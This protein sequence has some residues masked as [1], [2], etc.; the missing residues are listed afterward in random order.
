MMN[1]ERMSTQ[2][3]PIIYDERLPDSSVPPSDP[4]NPK[5]I[6]KSALVLQDQTKADTKFDVKPPPYERAGFTNPP[7]S[8]FKIPQ[9]PT[10]AL[11]T[12]ILAL[13]T[14]LVLK[15]LSTP[16]RVLLSVGAIVGLH[17]LAGRAR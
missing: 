9:L 1:V 15:P 7:S 5:N 10:L 16:L 13:L 3:I 8:T 2:Q 17:S 4:S 12:M 14:V 6:V 11:V